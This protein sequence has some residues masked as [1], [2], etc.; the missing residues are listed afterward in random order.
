ML[1]SEGVYSIK[2]GTKTRMFGPP[3]MT[4][5]GPQES[6]ISTS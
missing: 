1:N 2:D 3:T 6:A 5:S 4:S